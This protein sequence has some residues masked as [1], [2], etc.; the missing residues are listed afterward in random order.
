MLQLQNPYPQI[1]Q[2]GAFSYGGSQMWSENNMVKQCGCG[3]VAAQDLLLYLQRK[4]V[5]GD[6]QR[7]LTRQTYNADVLRL[8]KHYFP[9]LPHF[10]LNGIML[11]AG[12]NRLFRERGL[13]YRARW[14]FS[15]GKLWDRIQEML[16]NDIPVILSV[17]PNFPAIWENNCL[18]FYVKNR[19]GEYIRS[20]ATKAHYFTATGM[21]DEWLR[22]SSW[23]RE[24]FVNRKAYMEYVHQHST[25]LFSNILYVKHI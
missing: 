25:Y 15:G 5:S 17:G 2:F 8:H 18:D 6:A 4:E 19:T 21:D 12:V 10:G 3:V 14:A 23:G 11:A 22:I 1:R 9:L 13:P 24:Y 20:T 16:N 7:V